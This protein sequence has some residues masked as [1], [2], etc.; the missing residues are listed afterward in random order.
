MEDV[1]FIAE[2]ESICFVFVFC[3]KFNHGVCFLSLSKS[4]YAAAKRTD[5]NCAVFR[6]RIIVFVP[7]KR[8]NCK[9][10]SIGGYKV[11]PIGFILG[12]DEEVVAL[13][14]LQIF[15]SYGVNQVAYKF[16]EAELLNFISLVSECYLKD[17]NAT[18]LGALADYIADHW[19]EVKDLPRRK[20]LELFYTEN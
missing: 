14:K 6:A 7:D 19:I 1:C 20:I 8:V 2:V 12:D 5:A 15:V 11:L 18:P 10:F 9:A 3:C 17:D 4:F 13:A 16:N